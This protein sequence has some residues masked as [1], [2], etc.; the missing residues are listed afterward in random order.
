MM[1]YVE[2]CAARLFPG[3][4]CDAC[5]KVARSSNPRR[6]WWNMPCFNG[7]SEAQQKQVVEEGYLE[8]GYQPEGQCLNGAEV[9]VTTMWDKFPG[10]R[11]YCRGCGIEFLSLV[12]PL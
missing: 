3:E 4:R 11:F 12:G 1:E 10:P 7:L 2:C 5:G 8:I 6:G 9:E